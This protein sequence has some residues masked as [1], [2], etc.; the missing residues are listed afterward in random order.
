MQDAQIT[1]T[2]QV[3]DVAAAFVAEYEARQ[4]LQTEMER[5]LVLAYVLGVMRCNVEALW[6][7]LATSGVFGAADPRALF[8]ECGGRGATMATLRQE[9]REELTRRGLIP[10]TAEQG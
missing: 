8:E 3:L 10:A 4:P 1:F 6:E 5:A 7:E 2:R 9:A